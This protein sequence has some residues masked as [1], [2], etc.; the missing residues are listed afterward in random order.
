MRILL[1]EDSKVVAL[2][3]I[4]ALQQQGHRVTHVQNGSAAVE[5]YQTE[6]PDMVFSAAERVFGYGA[7]DVIG[8]NVKMLMPPPYTHVANLNKLPSP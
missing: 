1:A 7:A 8:N 3:I 5:A 4:S 2:P 6:A